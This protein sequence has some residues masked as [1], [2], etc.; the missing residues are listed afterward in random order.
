MFGGSGA[1][2]PGLWAGVVD[3]R[4]VQGNKTD[5]DTAGYTCALWDDATGMENLH[6][7]THQKL[8]EGVFGIGSIPVAILPS[9]QDMK[10]SAL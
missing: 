4:D 8:G 3:R 1:G 7:T 2:T 6:F 9:C 10:T 5:L